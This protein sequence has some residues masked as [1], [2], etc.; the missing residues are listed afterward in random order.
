MPGDRP[1]RVFDRGWHWAGG[2]PWRFEATAGAGMFGDS[3]VARG[4][5]RTGTRNAA[6][7]RVAKTRPVEMVW[8]PDPHPHRWREFNEFGN[9]CHHPGCRLTEREHEETA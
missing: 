1:I 4:M 8:P 2:W 3:V 9:T 7:R 5:T 6:V